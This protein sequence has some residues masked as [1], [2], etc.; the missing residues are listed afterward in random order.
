MHVLSF[1]NAESV[2]EII[3][4][5]PFSATLNTNHPQRRSGDDLACHVACPMYAGNPEQAPIKIK[6]DSRMI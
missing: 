6:L 5:A 1:N 3:T 2:K 4:S